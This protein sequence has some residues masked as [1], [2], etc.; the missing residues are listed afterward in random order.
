MRIDE[1]SSEIMARI[2]PHLQA[3][4]ER[5]SLEVLQQLRE[6]VRQ[7]YLATA[8]FQSTLTALQEGKVDTLVIAQ[9]QDREGARC[10]Q[11]GFVFARDVETCPYDGAETT[12][13]VNV[14]EEVIRMAEAQGAE[15]EFVASAAV[16]D[17]RGVGA[18]LRF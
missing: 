10:T 16:E 9:D 18:L 17:L 8:G 4:R 14:V 12:G 11:C 3:E 7:D 1:S 15:I 6:R 13:G 2:E 5:A